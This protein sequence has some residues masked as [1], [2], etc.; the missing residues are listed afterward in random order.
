MNMPKCLT[1]FDNKPVTDNAPHELWVAIQH[2]A[3]VCEDIST[4]IASLRPADSDE[5]C[6]VFWDA[7]EQMSM[8][9]ASEATAREAFKAYCNN[10]K[11]EAFT[12]AN[13]LNDNMRK[14][15]NIDKPA[16]L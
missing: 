5:T 10:L 3:I 7:S 14:H 1:T 6:Y 11:G 4:N 2:G 16:N 13:E 12:E 9:Y 15:G 8:P